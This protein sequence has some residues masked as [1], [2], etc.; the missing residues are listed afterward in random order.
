M[1]DYDRALQEATT[2]AEAAEG[3][4][5]IVF[6]PGFSTF[7]FSMQPSAQAAWPHSESMQ[8]PQTSWFVETQADDFDHA[9]PGSTQSL[10]QPQRQQ[11]AAAEAA[12]FPTH[13]AAQPQNSRPMSV[14]H[15]AGYGDVH[16]P[17]GG[18]YGSLGRLAA[19]QA[20]ALGV[21]DTPSTGIPAAKAPHM[22]GYDHRAAAA[23]QLSSGRQTEP[24]PFPTAGGGGQPLP[25]SASAPAL[26]P[27]VDQ[28]LAPLLGPLHALQ[29]GSR[30]GLSP[31]DAISSVAPPISAGG[32]G[33]D[34]LAAVAQMRNSMRMHRQ[35]TSASSVNISKYSGEV[36][37]A[38]AAAAA[39]ASGAGHKQLPA[40]SKP[41]HGISATE[42]APPSARASRTHTMAAVHPAV[43]QGLAGT[44]A[45]GSTAGSVLGISRGGRDDISTGAADLLPDGLS[46]FG[47]MGSLDVSEGPLSLLAPSKH[48]AN[49]LQ[50]ADPFAFLP[51]R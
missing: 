22:S 27:P 35:M 26:E 31:Q 15:F 2:K 3:A 50:D 39:A 42:T 18:G 29:R 25:R 47:S 8:A 43:R 23:A 40:G 30:H 28:T 24:P 10:Q 21:A 34:M 38:A 41:A 16:P 48:Q 11:Y 12:I 7:P 36:D 19:L 17:V 9:L 49:G 6:P 37:P 44:G 33:G 14:S 46:D 4:G 5:Q 13:H 32:A 20:A 45:P 1:A 51:R